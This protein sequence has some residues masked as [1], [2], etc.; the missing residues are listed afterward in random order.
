MGDMEA[1][2]ARFEEEIASGGG[3]D[4]RGQNQ[5]DPLPPPPMIPPPMF[6]P[7]SLQGSGKPDQSQGFNEGQNKADNSQPNRG[8]GLGPN[9]SQNSGQNNF[10]GP[11]RP[12]GPRQ[13]GPGGPMGNRPMGPGGPMGSQGPGPMGPGGLGPGGPGPMGMGFPGPMGPGPNFSGPMNDGGMIGPM[14]PRMPGFFPPPVLPD[15]SE[16]MSSDNKP[17]QTVYSA[18]PV[19]SKK[20]KEPAESAI[21]PYAE[22]AEIGPVAANKPTPVVQ[23]KQQET[24]AFGPPGLMYGGPQALYNQNKPS[25][26]D[27]DAN[28]NKGKK[29]KYVRTAAGSKW[30]DP[31]LLDWDSN[32]YRI[33]CGDL[34]NE[35]TDDTLARVF[36][37]YPSFQK[38]RV[39]REK[40]NKKSRGYGFVSFKD[41]SDFIRAMREMNG[42]YVGNRPIKLRKSTWKDRNIDVVRKKVK[43]KKKL[44]YKI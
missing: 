10:S 40:N 38:A 1:E 4:D 2:M 42:K 39:V 19:L 22:E 20:A 8:G 30:E 25:S 6:I 24:F 44:G 14:P 5:F 31:T 34:G 15:F 3:P 13:M 21:N 29:K 43:E 41:P 17:S 32:D 36:N 11:V 33:F 23:P 9:H 37:K 26:S 28:K 18:A 35:V 16:Y 27:A 7:H 12:G